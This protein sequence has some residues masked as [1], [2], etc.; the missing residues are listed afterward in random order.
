VVAT[1][2]G[3]MVATAF[4]DDLVRRVDDENAAFV[5]GDTAGNAAGLAC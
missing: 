5:R 2:S 1:A 3:N 4:D